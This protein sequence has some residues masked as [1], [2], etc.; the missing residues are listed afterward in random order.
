MGESGRGSRNWHLVLALTGVFIVLVEGRMA[1]ELVFRWHSYFLSSAYHKGNMFFY[2]LTMI[3]IPGP[4]VIGVWE[5]QTIEKNMRGLGADDKAI[6]S[7]QKALIDI[8]IISYM[9]LTLC[10]GAISD[11]IPAP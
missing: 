10:V 11:L 6:S 4:L 2:I 3:L 8:L 5:I 9:I 1:M 7:R